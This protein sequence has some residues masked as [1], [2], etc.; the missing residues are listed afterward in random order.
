MKK[1]KKLMAIGMSVLMVFSTMSVGV[2]ASDIT[3]SESEFDITTTVGPEHQIVRVFERDTES[4]MIAQC[5]AE[6]EANN[7]YSEV[8]ALLLEL[9]ME[10]YAIDNLT[11]EDL[12]KYAVSPRIVTSVSYS[13]V[14]NNDNVTYLE[15][16]VAIAEAAIVYNAQEVMRQNLAN[17]IQTIDQDTYQ[18]SYMRVFYMVTYNWDE[19][20]TFS[21][22]AR[23][24]TMPFFRGKDV[25]GSVAQDCTVTPYTSSGY[26]EYDWSLSTLAGYDEYS[27]HINMTS[28][29][30]QNTVNGSFYG[31]GAIIELPNDSYSDTMSVYYSNYKAHY[32]YDGHVNSP[33]EPHWFNTTG[34][35]CHSTM[36]ISFNPSITISLTGVSG[37]LGLSGV[38]GSDVRKVD[39][40][41]HYT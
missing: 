1:F 28:S 21:T 22:D 3:N 25:I 19:S 39:L 32:Q 7:D 31:S 34:S 16:D 8:K 14:D 13:K 12:A 2:F 24:L 27:E 29:Q 15:E 20:Y 11:D 30:F 38:G 9:G 6:P 10:Q 36:K 41:I 33:A 26:V 18:D 17:G 37:S 5:S 40:E 35:Y 4:A 23:W